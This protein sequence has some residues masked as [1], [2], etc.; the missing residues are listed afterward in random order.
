[1]ELVH[2]RVLEVRVDD[3]DA[4][5]AGAGRT[6]PEKGLL[7]GGANGGNLPVVGS[8]KNT[9]PGA[10]LDRQRAPIESA[11]ERLDLQH[12]P[13]VVQAVPAAHEQAAVGRIPGEAGARSEV[14][15]V[16]LPLVVHE[17]Q[18]DRVELVDAA[19]V[20]DL[21]VDLITQPDDSIAGGSTRLQSSW[22]NP[23][24]CV[25]SASGW[26]SAW[27]GL[28]LRKSHGKQQVVVIDDSVAGVIEGGEVCDELDATLLKDAEP[29]FGVDALQLA[30]EPHAVGATNEGRRV[31]ELQAAS[32]ASP[33]A[34]GTM[35]RPAG[36]GTSAAAHCDRWVLVEERAD[37][38]AERVDEVALRRGRPRPEHAVVAVGRRPVAGLR[39]RGRVPPRWRPCRWPTLPRSV[40]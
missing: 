38:A 22:M 26:N 28:P 35:R 15:Q 10:D 20:V 2:R 6:N 7:F 33:A 24:T 25:L 4:R 32:G 1:M 30:T 17:R 23:A 3:V 27:S 12:D 18:D 14:V 31:R 16:A 29:E 5:G 19:L 36:S 39:N 37:A 34:F 11:L 8:R 13:V 9:L 40:P 21:G